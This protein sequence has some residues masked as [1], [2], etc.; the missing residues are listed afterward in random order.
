M[1]KVLNQIR[2]DIHSLQHN[3]FKVFIREHRKICRE[4]SFELVGELLIFIQCTKRF[5]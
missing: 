1:S 3:R 2:T 5:Q 4:G